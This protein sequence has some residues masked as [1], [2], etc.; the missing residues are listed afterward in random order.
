[1]QSKEAIPAAEAKH[2]QMAAA[3]KVLGMITSFWVSQTLFAAHDLGVF[4]EL[5]EGP[6]TATE[7]ASRLGFNEQAGDRL[8]TA[9][10]AIGLLTRDGEK[11]S[12]AADTQALLV[13]GPAG[14]MGGFLAHARNDLYALWGHLDSA[15]KENSPRWK[16]AFKSRSDNPFEEMYKDPKGLRDF[17]Y[18]MRGGSITAVQGMLEVYDFNQ[19]KCFMDVG[20]ALG[21]VS[22]AVAQKY[23]HLK[24]ISFD[25]P[26]VKPLAEEYIASEG[27][28][29]RVSTAAGDMFKDELPR[30]ADAIH[31]SWILHDW[32]DEQ[33]ATILRNCYLAL[34]SGGTILLG[35]G[36]MNDDGTGPLFGA[37][38]SLNM[39]V[40]TDGGRERTAS[41][42]KKLLEGA[43]F[44]D[45]KAQKL[46]SMRD[47]ITARKP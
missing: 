11:Y 41:E 22:V 8:L 10:V 4:K 12:N 36:L 34:P 15:V 37:L 13:P 42:Y 14:Y 32:S 1:M 7:L 21:T 27:V 6:A 30:G 28:A 5:S 46:E 39:L 2:N 33:C 43:G 29:D 19:H 24:A 23:P 38:M 47:L 40:A 3:Q 25:L 45:V 26:P 35:E 31:M 18:A 9:C 44:T 16:Q 20:G 17:M